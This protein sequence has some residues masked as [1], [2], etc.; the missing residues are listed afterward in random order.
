MGEAIHDVL[1]PSGEATHL[2]IYTTIRHDQLGIKGIAI[3][4]TMVTTGPPGA[5]RSHGGG[6]VPGLDG[7][8]DEDDS[9]VDEI[10]S[11]SSAERSQSSSS[12]HDVE[13]RHSD[14]SASTPDEWSRSEGE[15]QVNVMLVALLSTL[16]ISQ[17][18]ES[19][20]QM[21][22]PPHTQSS[23]LHAIKYVGQLGPWIGFEADTLQTF[24][25]QLF[26]PSPISYISTGPLGNPLMEKH[27]HVG[28][29][30]GVQGRFNDRIGQALSLI[31]R[32][33]HSNFSFA[34]PL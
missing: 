27:I 11:L 8:A 18:S 21:P 5:T 25:S 23:A 3:S 31:A 12:L 1:A 10:S 24:N 14:S 28:D 16:T 20:S 4:A 2:G 29:E 7:P 22:V 34:L 17:E 26:H 13:S 15:D 30:Y 9:G 33:Q 6:V 32:H 19:P